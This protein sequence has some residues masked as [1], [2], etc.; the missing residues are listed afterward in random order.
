M[1]LPPRP[2]FTMKRPAWETPW[3]KHGMGRSPWELRQRSRLEL[4][5]HSLEGVQNRYLSGRR[6]AGGRC[7][8]SQVECHLA[9]VQQP[10]RPHS[11]SDS[12][13]NCGKFRLQ[14]KGISPV[15]SWALVDVKFITWYGL[16][17]WPLAVNAREHFQERPFLGKWQPAVTAYCAINQMGHK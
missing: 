14:R 5:L 16:Y 10:L 4:S 13:G 11:D 15:S 1:S 17:A 2:I 7:F 3:I 12:A 8:V 6:T 9:G